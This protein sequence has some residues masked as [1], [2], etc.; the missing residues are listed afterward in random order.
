ML[1]SE[2]LRLDT[3]PN[4]ILQGIVLLYFTQQK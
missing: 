1:V 4:A 2:N 3:G